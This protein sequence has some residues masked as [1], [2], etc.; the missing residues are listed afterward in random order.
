MLTNKPLTIEG[1]KA[2]MAER[3]TKYEAARKFLTTQYTIQ[4]NKLKKLLACLE[5]EQ[6]EKADA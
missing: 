6:P 2:E 4:Q 3:K 5:G 1:V